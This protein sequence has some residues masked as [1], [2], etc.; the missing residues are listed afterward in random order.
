MNRPASQINK[1]S[2]YSG[3][4]KMYGASQSSGT[5]DMDEKGKYGVYFKLPGSLRNDI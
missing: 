2:N 4:I 3:S 5:A 1:R